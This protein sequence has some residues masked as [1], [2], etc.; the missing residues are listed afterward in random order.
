MP[1]NRKVQAGVVG[2]ALGIIVAWVIRVTTDIDV[3][4]EIGGAFSTVFGGVLGWFI[5]ETRAADV[6]S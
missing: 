4:A 2:G 1:V 5:P 6:P 3:P